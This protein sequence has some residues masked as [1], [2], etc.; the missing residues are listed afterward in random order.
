MATHDTLTLTL[1]RMRFHAAHG[2]LPSEKR[3][4][5]PWEVTVTLE[6]RDAAAADDLA[7]TIDYRRVHAV[8]SAVMNGP[9]RNLAETLAACIAQELLREFEQAR[10]VEVE[11]V[12]VKPPVDFEFE[13]LRVRVRR[14]RRKTGG[15]GARPAVEYP[16]SGEAQ[17][18]GLPDFSRWLSEAWRATPPEKR[19]KKNC[20]PEGCQIRARPVSGTPPGC[21]VFYHIFRWC[22]ALTRPQPPA[23]ICQASGLMK[24][25]SSLLNGYAAES[26]RSG[27][28]RAQFS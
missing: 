8:V 10:T 22:R 15:A 6:L 17:A 4:R 27:S 14:E 24:I 2:A 12:K 7:R 18:G 9:P 25:F 1:S 3:R 5:Q 26:R 13:G 21:G 19:L 11:V 28:L 20:I 16:F 23:K